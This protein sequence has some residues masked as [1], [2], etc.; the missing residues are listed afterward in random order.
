VYPEPLAAEVTDARRE[1][2]TVTGRTE[3]SGTPA[4]L[5]AAGAPA[6]AIT[7]WTGPWPI[8]ER[9]WDPAHALRQ[10]RFQ[11]LTADGRAWLAV[12]QDGGWLLEASY[13]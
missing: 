4:W 1:L 9:W 3:L 11:L 12:V 13:D 8:S 5:A 6:R 2:V 10:A 7:S